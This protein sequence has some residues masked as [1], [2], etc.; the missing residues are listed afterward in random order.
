MDSPI[1]RASLTASILSGASNAI[2]QAITCYRSN[3]SIQATSDV[4]TMITTFASALHNDFNPID[5]FHF[6]L[7]SLLACPPNYLWQSWL[8]G[9]FPGY[10]AKLSSTQQEKLVDDVTTGS[11][12][13]KDTT[14]GSLK[15]RRGEKDGAMTEKS[16]PTNPG[17]A[18]VKAEKKLNLVNTLIKFC[19]DQTL[20]AAVNTVLFIA[21]IA[22]LRGLSF[23]TIQQNVVEQFWPMI[24]AGQKLW[25]IVSVCQFT[26]VPFE[27]RTLVGSTVGLFWGVLLSLMASPG[28][29]KV[30]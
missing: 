28:K 29:G 3:P 15:K 17:K 25:P 1:A 2:A 22:L 13:S 11:S 24:R 19:L 30:E 10:T 5:L 23:D 16:T 14:N 26:I 20:G 7:F 27:W 8:E 21:G 12:T 18:A 9:R 4:P 6:M